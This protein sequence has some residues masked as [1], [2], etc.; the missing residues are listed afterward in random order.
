MSQLRNC[1]FQRLVQNE[2]FF[3]RNLSRFIRGQYVRTSLLLQL[4]NSAGELFLLY[5]DYGLRFGSVEG[6][7]CDGVPSFN[8]H[9]L[10]ELSEV[11]EV[12]DRSAG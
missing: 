5:L 4:R 10:L 12:V 1:K 9:D 7:Y 11:D 8:S 3:T 2:I 6:A